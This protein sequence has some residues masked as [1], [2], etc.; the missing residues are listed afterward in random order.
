[1]NERGEQLLAF[2]DRPYGLPVDLELI[3]WE[4]D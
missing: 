2:F 4:A 3:V 1:M